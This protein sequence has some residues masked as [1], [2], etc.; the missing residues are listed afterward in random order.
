MKVP[1]RDAVVKAS[2]NLL[3]SMIGPGQLNVGNVDTIV[4]K[5]VAQ[6]MFQSNWDDVI[7]SRRYHQDGRHACMG[8]V[9]RRS[10]SITCGLLLRRAAAKVE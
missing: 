3:E 8:D 6:E 7:A 10:A 2:R 4:T 1:Q 5:L 9:P